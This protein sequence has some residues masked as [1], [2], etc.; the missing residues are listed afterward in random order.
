LR[1]K[2]IAAIWPD[3]CW[4]A[5]EEDNSS[6]EAMAG[7]HRRSERYLL[8]GRLVPMP[9]D[10]AI[11]DCQRYVRENAWDRERSALAKLQE[12]RDQQLKHLVRV[13]KMLT[14]VLRIDTTYRSR[15]WV[16]EPSDGWVYKEQRK[17]LCDNEQWCLEH[18]T[19][20]VP[21]VER[22]GV[23][24]IRTSDL[25]PTQSVTNPE[26]YLS[27]T[28]DVLR[29]LR[30][31]GIRHGDLT[32]QSV[33][34]RENRPWL[35]DFAESRLVGDPRPDKRPEGDVHWLHKTMRQQAVRN[36]RSPEIWQAI[37]TRVDFAGKTVLDVGCGDGDM[38]LYAH[39]AGAAS[40][41]GIDKDPIKART[42]ALR[43]GA[44]VTPRVTVQAAILG[45]YE[46][47]IRYDIVLC[48]SVLPYVSNMGEA[49][50]KLCSLARTAIIECQYAG[51][52]PGVVTDDG[53]MLEKLTYAGW[54]EVSKIGQTHVQDRDK[55]RSI[56]LCNH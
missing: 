34:C 44:I 41:V 20:Y 6:T 51:D 33:L 11:I 56:W 3:E 18:M 46:P 21:A 17:T 39:N 38:L 43:V 53:E 42:T 10:R 45:M 29:T 30:Q 32:E 22:V 48:L 7:L 55:Y 24:I 27:H 1:A 16:R 25:G 37:K 14:N 9:N 52:G 23:E 26:L 47:A 35:V 12:E 2:D 40:V 36:E 15:V 54:T 8:R 5:G 50:M 19:D 31:A 13:G 4:L 28:R 49:L